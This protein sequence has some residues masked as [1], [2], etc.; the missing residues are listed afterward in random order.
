M[1]QNFSRNIH[2]EPAFVILEKASYIPENLWNSQND[3]VL[4]SKLA[5]LSSHLQLG[6]QPV[7]FS[8]Q[9]RKQSFR[10]ALQSKFFLVHLQF[11]Q[12]GLA[13]LSVGHSGLGQMFVVLS[14]GGP[15]LHLQNGGNPPLIVGHSKNICSSNATANVKH[16]T[17]TTNPNRIYKQ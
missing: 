16:Q 3:D 8:G 12:D 11:G 9:T 1:K 2:I 4:L 10:Q 17:H 6:Q 15:Y 5:N 14:Y 7:L 13:T